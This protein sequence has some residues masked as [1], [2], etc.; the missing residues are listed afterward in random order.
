MDIAAICA[1]HYDAHKL[2]CSGFARAVAKDVGVELVGLANQIV[3]TL[4]TE[5]DGWERLDNGAQAAEAAKSRLVLAGLRGDDQTKP[6]PHGHL[7]VVVPGPLNRGKYPTAWWGSLAGNPRQNETINW[8]WTE[9][10][11]DKV[12]YAAHTVTV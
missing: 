2:D 4:A 10:D 11:R 9:Q 5:S 7:V 12:V 3:D 8:A 6:D 1:K